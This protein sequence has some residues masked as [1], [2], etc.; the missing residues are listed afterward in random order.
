MN[1][2][3]PSKIQF[4]IQ[5]IKITVVGKLESTSP[6]ESQVAFLNRP[7]KRGLAEMPANWQN[8]TNKE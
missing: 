4:P 6:I 1:R 7:S 2:P 8:R 3:G 5:A